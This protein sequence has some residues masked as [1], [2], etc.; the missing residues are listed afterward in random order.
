MSSV[1]DADLMTL[2]DWEARKAFVRFG[3]DDALML[4]ELHLVARAYAEEV[5]NELYGRWMRTPELRAFFKDDATLA[6][7]RDLQ[8]RY[9]VRLTLG[10]YG[11]EYLY[12]RLHIGAVHR[13]V[14]LSPRWY[15]GAYSTYLEIVLPRVMDAFEYD[16]PK[17]RRAVI[18]LTKLVSLDQELALVSY[19]AG[20]PVGP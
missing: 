16:K 14:G 17:K 4:Q 9:F 7:V 8:K 11:K 18:A 2:A 6:R 19:F 10:D 13:K 12:D 5:M 3:A 20:D 1:E 15:M